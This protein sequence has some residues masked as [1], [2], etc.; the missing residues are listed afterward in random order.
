MALTRREVLAGTA[1]LAAW[2]VL[3]NLSEAA[4][5]PGG[6]LPDGALVLVAQLTAKPGKED[7]MKAALVE[8][9]APTLKE[10]GCLCYNLH[11]S[12]KDKAQFMFY[13]Q[14]A[15]KEALDKHGKSPHMKT[16]Q[17]KLKGLVAK[18]GATFYELL[19]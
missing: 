5:V 14:W 10:E 8:M 18:G 11:Q 15:S 2:P 1:A 16:M 7:E 13:E 19:R 12:N 4:E 6:K 3:G 9:V 17:G